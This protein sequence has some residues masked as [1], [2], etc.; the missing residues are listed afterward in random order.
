VSAAALPRASTSR[1]SKRV[2]IGD[3]IQG[4]DE[5]IGHVEDFVVDDQ[6]WTVRYL[7][8][9]GVEILPRF[10]VSVGIPIFFVAFM[11]L[12]YPR[13]LSRTVGRAG[14]SVRASDAPT[15]VVDMQPPPLFIPGTTESRTYVL[16]AAPGGSLSVT[17]GAYSTPDERDGRALE[18]GIMVG[19]HGQGGEVD[20]PELVKWIAATF[21]DCAGFREVWEGEW[22]LADP[23]LAVI[24]ERRLA[25][26][27]DLRARFVKTS[28]P[29]TVPSI[30]ASRPPALRTE[31]LE[32]V[33]RWFPGMEER[34]P[35]YAAVVA[36]TSWAPM[37]SAAYGVNCGVD[38]N[39]VRPSEWF[40]TTVGNGLGPAPRMIDAA[41]RAID[42]ILLDSD[43]LVRLIDSMLMVPLAAVGSF[44]VGWELE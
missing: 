33:L 19:R 22:S 43:G 20:S 35:R 15:I 30:I 39:D 42:A 29:S 13:V 12:T 31:R 32:W 21:A 3:H 44:W 2:S 18:T 34:P 26:H 8:I 7:M 24:L 27:A 40:Q 38:L 1:T 28:D 17:R 9:L 5:A 36:S 4:R 14:G 37:T 11:G 10:F 6:T 25:A 41:R 16:R 23:A